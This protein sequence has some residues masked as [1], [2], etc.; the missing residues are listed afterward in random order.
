MTSSEMAAWVQAIGSLGSICVSLWIAVQVR[1]Y[2]KRKDKAD[3]VQSMW[4]VQQQMNI[5]TVDSEAQIKASEMMVYGEAP[6]SHLEEVRLNYRIFFMINRVRHL[7]ESYKAG[8]LTRNE[9]RN[10][11]LPTLQLIVA[12]KPRVLKLLETRGY[13]GHFANEVEKL[14]LLVTPPPRI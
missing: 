13:E 2:T 11:S 5:A 7:Y 8:I 1:R 14:L 4:L 6:Q 10:H 9:F 12:H 3:L